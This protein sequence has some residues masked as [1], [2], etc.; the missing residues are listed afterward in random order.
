MLLH[1]LTETMSTP[2]RI[3]SWLHISDVHARHGTAD[4]QL[5]QQLVFNE[6]LESVSELP[7]GLERV[8]A[9]FVTG[10]LATTGGARD[11]AEYTEAAA[12]LRD[13][14][15]Q[16]G[17]EADRVF[18]VPGNHD[19]DRGI[20]WAN[21]E[22]MASLQQLRS[23]AVS[24]LN[25]PPALEDQFRARWQGWRQ[26]VAGLTP[27]LVQSDDGDWSVDLLGGGGVPLRLVGLN[28]A[29]LSQ[30]DND[31]G[32]LWI[33]RRQAQAA[34]ARDRL[35]VALGHHPLD[36]LAD[37]CELLGPLRRWMHVYLH[38]HVH[39]QASHAV[40]H[41]GGDL[42]VTSVAGAVHVDP[43]ERGRLQHAYSFGALTGDG[44]HS[45]S[46]RVWP[47]MYDPTR[48]FIVDA[49]NCIRDQSHA[50]L[51]LPTR[52]RVAIPGPPSVPAVAPP[53]PTMTAPGLGI[54]RPPLE[55]YIAWDPESTDAPPI[56]TQLYRWLHGGVDD[57]FGHAGLGIPVFF[58]FTPVPGGETPLPV[59]FDRADAT[60]VV[61]LM[62]AASVGER[63]AT[64][65]A[66]VGS[67]I[68]E[69]D[70]R[71]GRKRVVPVALDEGIFRFGALNAHHFIRVAPFEGVDLIDRVVDGVLHHLTRLL[72][73]APE[74]TADTA[75]PP[76]VEVFLSYA[77]GDGSG[78][79]D[80]LREFLLDGTGVDAFLDRHAMV[81][82]WT[83][84][85]QIHEQ[86]S[87]PH[88]VLVAVLTDTFASRDT[89]VREVATAKLETRPM[90][91]VDAREGLYVDGLDD[92]ASA[93]T[94]RWQGGGPDFWRAFLH[95][96]LMEAL[97]FQC[98]PAYLRAIEELW[99]GSSDGSLHVPR[100]PSV[101]DAL[102]KYSA[103]LHPDPPLV[104]ERHQLFRQVHE[105]LAI[106]TPTTLPLLLK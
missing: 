102:A 44:V 2:N 58:R 96:I 93:P 14:R 98:V 29:L 28:T 91:V 55:V 20:A 40:L 106:M 5:D 75:P 12:F 52:S 65:R 11:A 69:C 46:L 47:R 48:G 76:P 103:L 42:H 62:D 25:R 10:D 84:V 16:L 41:G 49:R 68:A 50:E 81:P 73:V 87:A 54:F 86:I 57:P 19:V 35:V 77:R 94:L 36:W 33:G 101:S 43:G 89:C 6:L 45:V 63:G 56:A 4:D 80:R 9:I 22:L 37:S 72:R 30:D 23:G 26:L 104:P 74:A 59:D 1:S 95:T 60:A 66:Y 99:R 67:L 79:A 88:V 64:F 83:F 70:R 3:L 51:P 85:A 7:P 53:S 61:A 13:A 78:V 17:V 15:Q 34:F 8:D 105:T 97:R 32:N 21:P 27:N 39:M 92:L 38:G 18:L 24:V 31:R 82:A 71:G 100:T 90:I